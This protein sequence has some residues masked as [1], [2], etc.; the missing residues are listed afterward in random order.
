METAISASKNQI[1]QLTTFRKILLLAGIFSSLLYVAMNI[2]AAGLYEGYDSASQTVSEL[3]AIGTPTRQLW[4]S[5]GFIYTILII[6]FGFGVRISGAHNRFLRTTGSLLIVY[7]IIGLGWPMA[8]M[9]QRQALAAGEKTLSDTMHLVFSAVTVLLM[10]TAIAFGA[11]SFGRSFRIYSI[12]TII[13]L[14]G[15][16]IWTGIDA[17]NL[18]ANLPT[19]WLGI[20]E[21]ILIATFLLW[22]IVLAAIL[23]RDKARKSYSFA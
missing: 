6:A 2:I 8:P 11:K 3:S 4:T 12:V 23:L 14:L 1:P 22:I 13:L 10:L 17:P 18:E 15:F 16:G 19:P 21:R 20:V 7:G 5:L 9:H